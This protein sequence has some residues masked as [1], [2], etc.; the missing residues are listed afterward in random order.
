[1]PTSIPQNL[2]PSAKSLGAK[3]SAQPLQRISLSSG[4]DRVHFSGNT[5]KFVTGFNGLPFFADTS[6]QP[7]PRFFKLSLKTTEKLRS[8]PKQ[9]AKISALLEKDY[10]EHTNFRFVF[11]K[12]DDQYQVL[13]MGDRNGKKDTLIGYQHQLWQL[14]VQLL[15]HDINERISQND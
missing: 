9:Q 3:Q 13:L 11:S 5:T 14:S 7:L 2:Q 12:E 10:P 15:M 6:A 4:I 1:M 8:I